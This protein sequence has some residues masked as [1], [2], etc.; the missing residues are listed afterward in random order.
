[1]SRMSQLALITGASSGIGAEYARQLAARGCDLIV[2]AR[3]A[4][5]L[6]QL[7]ED[8][9]SK[10]GVSVEVCAVD[11][12]EDEGIDRL[13]ARIEA[14]PE[15]HYLINNAGFGTMGNLGETDQ[16]KQAQ[17]VRL[18]V[19]ATMRL[20][21]AAVPIMR[22]QKQGYIINVSSIAAFVT[23]PGNVNYCATKAYLNSFSESLQL[24][25]KGTGVKVQALCPGYTYSEFHDRPEMSDFSRNSMPDFLWKSAEFMVSDSLKQLDSS[26]VIVIPGT[27]YKLMVAGL[28]N[29]IMRIPLVIY[30]RFLGK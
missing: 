6:V 29:P 24:E 3:R 11:L 13:V 14:L 25:M 10:Y 5:K 1:M 28:K 20:T 9:E 27:V 8:I 15:L 16:T 21:Q 23:G 26:K 4:T 22:R 7:K 2:V 19:M 12:S 17:M 18:H 30:Q